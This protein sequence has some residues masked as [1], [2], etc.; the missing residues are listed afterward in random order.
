MR[1]N[2]KKYQLP[3]L[4]SATLAIAL[5]CVLLRVMQV[6]VARAPVRSALMQGDAGS[7]LLVPDIL[8]FLFSIHG[9]GLSLKFFWTPVTYIFLHDSATHLALNIAGLL[10]F[11][12]M[13]EREF[14][15]RVMLGSFLVSGIIGGLGWVAFRGLDSMQPCVGASAAV[16]GV[17]GA[18]AALRPKEEFE[19]AIPFF[20]THIRVW[21][22]AVFL[23]VANAL[24]LFFGRGNIAYSAHLFGIVSGGVCGLLARRFG[25]KTRQL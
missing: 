18:Y 8:T 21:E 6:I 2:F 1:I 19:L 12:T 11:G 4:P 7:Y 24:E 14:G 10:A 5:V 9:L 3:R 23:V 16:L 20:R 17:I 15:K 22:L 13:L 25:S